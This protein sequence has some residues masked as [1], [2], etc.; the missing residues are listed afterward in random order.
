MRVVVEYTVT[1][2][3]ESELRE[4]ALA[5]YRSL[6]AKNDAEFPWD[7]EIHVTQVTTD[8][9]ALSWDGKVTIRLN[10]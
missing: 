9:G 6:V 5:K 1:G 7:A 8:D 4:A 2:T 10:D 3:T